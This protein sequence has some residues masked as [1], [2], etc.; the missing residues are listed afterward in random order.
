MVIATF[1]LFPKMLSSQSYILLDLTLTVAVLCPAS[2]LFNPAVDAL[3]TNP[4]VDS[5]D[6]WICAA[7]AARHHAYLSEPIKNAI[8]R[9][10]VLKD[11]WG[12]LI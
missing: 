1:K 7:V 8:F 5:R 10:I 6:L 3:F 9:L 12:M 4:D 11:Y 2:Y